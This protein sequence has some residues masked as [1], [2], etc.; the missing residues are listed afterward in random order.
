MSGDVP[1]SIPPDDGRE[2]WTR[3]VAAS[4]RRAL[5]DPAVRAEVVSLLCGD[6]ER[7][8]R[9]LDQLA[10]ELDGMELTMRLRNDDE[11]S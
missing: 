11:A 3:T 4:I 2:A 8:Q 6:D 7:R 5:D 10:A 9:R 1:D